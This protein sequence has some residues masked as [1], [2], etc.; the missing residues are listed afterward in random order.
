M[1]IYKKCSTHLHE[2]IVVNDAS[3]EKGL[4]SGLNF[5]K[6]SVKGFPVREIEL[7]ENVGFL[8][9]SNLGLKEA[10]GDIVILVSTDVRIFGDLVSEVKNKL[11]VNPKSLIGGRVFTGTTGWNTFGT[12][13]FGYVEGYLLA[14]TR[15]GWKELDYF[16]E[17]YAPNDFEDID[18]S[19]TA[20]KLGYELH[21]ITEGVVQHLGAKSILYGN[22][23]EDLTKRNQEKFRK[24]W[25][26]EK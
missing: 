1:D 23:R 19:T 4:G 25:M 11:F 9:A 20:V 14:T 17:I 26:N 18:L 13:T 5:W 24:K 10:T 6:V 12:K 2:V 15:D 22:D 3:T 21:Q 8:R 7:P 16:D